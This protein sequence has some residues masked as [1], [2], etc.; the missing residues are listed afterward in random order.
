MTKND[1]C[2]K[3]NVPDQIFT[4]G[5]P[6]WHPLDCERNG[7]WT[8]KSSKI[9]TKTNSYKCQDIF[10]YKCDARKTYDLA[11]NKYNSIKHYDCSRLIRPSR[12]PDDAGSDV[13]RIQRKMNLPGNEDGTLNGVALAAQL[14]V[15]REKEPDSCK[16]GLVASDGSFAPW[17]Q[18][19]NQIEQ[20]S[21][22][23][24]TDSLEPGGTDSLTLEVKSHWE[25]DLSKCC[26]IYIVSYTVLELNQ[27]ISGRGYNRG[28]AL[29]L[30]E[31]TEDKYLFDPD[32]PE[33]PLEQ[34]FKEPIVYKIPKNYQY[35]DA[36]RPYS[37]NSFEGMANGEYST[38]K[39][40]NA[41][42][43]LSTYPIP[44]CEVSTISNINTISGPKSLAP[45]T[46]LIAKIK[47]GQIVVPDGLPE[48]I[49]E[50]YTLPGSIGNSAGRPT[51]G[52]D[53]C[54]GIIVDNLELMKH[55]HINQTS[56]T[57]WEYIFEFCEHTVEVPEKKL[58]TECHWKQNR[59]QKNC[60][61]GAVM[62]A[63]S[64]ATHNEITEKI[65]GQNTRPDTLFLVEYL[66]G[67]TKKWEYG[68]GVLPYEFAN[69]VDPG[70]TG[71]Y[72]DA[73]DL[74]RLQCPTPT[75]P[76]G[77][78]DHPYSG[79]PR[80]LSLNRCN[81]RTIPDGQGSPAWTF[82]GCTLIKDY[83]PPVIDAGNYPTVD[84]D[85]K[86]KTKP[87]GTISEQLAAF[88]II[89]GKSVAAGAE[90][91]DDTGSIAIGTHVASYA[92]QPLGYLIGCGIPK[93]QERV[94]DNSFKLVK[95]DMDKFDIKQKYQFKYYPDASGGELADGYTSIGADNYVA[96]G[97]PDPSVPGILKGGAIRSEYAGDKATDEYGVVNYD[98]VAP[99]RAH[100]M[101]QDKNDTKYINCR[102][103]ILGDIVY[104]PGENAQF[105]RKQ[106]HDTYCSAVVVK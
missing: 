48:A 4:V 101:E 66:Y 16:D 73:L 57:S 9:S 11:E 72:D 64:K 79:V 67:E 24:T 84:A 35:C 85:L 92:E 12:Q 49:R 77:I 38:G 93:Q 91:P 88:D 1:E 63:V 36:F 27:M 13:C 62:D 5:K 105:Y 76:D 25:W 22:C 75:D 6:C 89:S 54:S 37:I 68:Q 50:G 34:M 58:D 20:D 2:N 97:G 52:A 53:V 3:V 96:E 65:D 106:I 71:V 33:K 55:T 87:T 86:W 29:T 19:T 94:F 23:N 46:E 83:T 26:W 41:G 70:D 90:P 60:L 21:E 82:D 104:V 78:Y 30:R 14:L 7:F 8:S 42:L 28:T 17:I 61:G 15:A 44:A 18:T 40:E 47:D 43:N 32:S 81:A 39:L 45:E 69:R 51:C 100:S 31:L 10:G 59:R 98:Y 95:S 103:Q 80:G 56:K 74:Y 99:P 102:V